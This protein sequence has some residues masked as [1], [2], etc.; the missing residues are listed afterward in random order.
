MPPL[1]VI[2]FLFDSR[3]LLGPHF[4]GPSWDRWRAVLRA[5]F[6][7]PMS[8]RD[9]E[10]F[11]EVAGDRAP[12][13]RRVRELVCAVGRGG[14]KDSIAAGLATYIAATGDFSRL[15]PGERGVVLTLATDR[16][17]AGI[18]FNYCRGFFTEVPALAVMVERIN[19]QTIEL[20]TKAQI[21]VGTNNL[22]APRGRTICCAIYDE[23]AFWYDQD[24][25]NP[26][27]EVDTAISPGLMRFP[28]SLKI[29]IS[30]VNKRS[31]LLYDRVTEYFGK[32]SDDVL[33]VMGESLQFNPSLDAALIERELQRDPER[34]GA[35]YLSRWRDDL[36]NFLDRQLVE[37]AVDPGVVVR[38]PQ[39]GLKYFAFADPSGGR[40]DSFAVG[41]AHSDNDTIILDA[42]YEARSPFTPSE[43]VA[44]I[45]AL[46]SSYGIQRAT[47]DAYG[48]G[49]VEDAFKRVG[50]TY[51]KSKR[52]RSKIYLDALPL[53]TSGRARI[54]DNQRLIHQFISLE[55]RTSAIG[56]D[57]VTHP[58]HQSAHDDLA[59]AVAGA[60]VLAVDAASSWDAME[61]RPNAFRA[62]GD[63]LLGGEIPPVI[64]E[65]PPQRRE[66]A[67]H[68]PPFLSPVDVAN[69]DELIDCV[70]PHEIRL[71]VRG[72]VVRIQPGRQ[73]LPSAFLAMDYVQLNGVVAV[74]ESEAG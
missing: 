8:I 31:G 23:V 68:W 21:T 73:S 16:E 33:V 17:Q 7:L 39:R 14:G 69:G 71:T 64:D 60:L 41:I 36:S 22:R 35:E 58:N 57:T 32:D 50:I 56:R 42:L 63:A 37:A 18:A 55:R 27:I 46:L 51:E 9:L 44:E 67:Q 11:H 1:N 40:G 43:I 19:D 20:S 48:A 70:V 62:F 2:D 3:A 6:A 34:A 38:P 15:R 28:G 5:A 66:P 59:N 53:F 49:W 61:R 13:T 26:D 25:A 12:P 30:S 74:V 45:A 29:L 47:G 52:D 54:L 65:P 4:E 24:Y 10:L 72:G